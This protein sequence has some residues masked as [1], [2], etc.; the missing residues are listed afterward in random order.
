MSGINPGAQ[1]QAR[2]RLSALG[3]RRKTREAQD[4][5]WAEDVKKVLAEARVA[6]VPMGEAAN[7]LGLNRTTLYQVYLYPPEPR[8]QE[9]A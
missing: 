5:K 3:K 4:Q 2:R 1:G 9:P 8:E 6:G 7:R